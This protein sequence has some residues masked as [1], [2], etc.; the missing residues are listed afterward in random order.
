MA[1]GVTQDRFFYDTLTLMLDSYN[2]IGAVKD[3]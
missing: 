2:P 1:I 3:F